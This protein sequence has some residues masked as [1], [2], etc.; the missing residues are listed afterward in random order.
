MVRNFIQLITEL[1]KAVARCWLLGYFEFIPIQFIYRG[2]NTRKLQY[3]PRRH[4]WLKMENRATGD[5]YY[6]NDCPLHIL[7]YFAIFNQSGWY[8][9]ANRY[10]QSP[11]T[12]PWCR[13]RIPLLKFKGNHCNGIFMICRDIMWYLHLHLWVV[14]IKLLFSIYHWKGRTYGLTYPRS[15]KWN[16]HLF[17]VACLSLV[18]I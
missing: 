14:N 16:V 1:L 4:N 2:K 10:L 7:Y 17:L 3:V 12:F 15:V 8:I 13:Y 5:Q 18:H 6:Y 9:K 11:M